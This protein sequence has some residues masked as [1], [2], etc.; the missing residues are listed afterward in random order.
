[1]HA[2]FL[3]FGDIADIVIP[4]GPTSR[5]RHRGFAFVEYED[6]KDCT[7]AVENMNLA[8]LYG[9]TLKVSMAKP[10]FLRDAFSKRP[11]WE[12]DDYIQK[13]G[14]E[15]LAGDDGNQ[16]EVTGSGESAVPAVEQGASAAAEAEAATKT[17]EERIKVF[18]EIS[19][20]GNAAGAGRI[21]MELRNDI[22]PR[23]A[24]NFRQLCT[25]SKGFGFRNSTF[26]RIIPGFM[27]QGGDFTKHNGTGGKSIYGA[28][29]DDENFKLK[30]TGPG[31]LSMANS[32]PNS[33]GSQFFI[34]TGK[35]DWLD[36][37]HVVFG[38]VLE[39]MPVV[40]MMEKCGSSSGTPSKRVVI[41][42]CGELSS[43]S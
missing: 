10:I 22:V 42:D 7:D 8:E 29:F 15:P 32:G 41:T 19:I 1:M 28:K 21:V 39:G 9:R 14:K 24:E 30:H 40:R 4:P 16:R 18:F 25:G 38:R 11:V 3:P 37:K 26:H 36:G 20:G 43:S 33:N 12:Q 6:A 17:T 5:Y 34:T 23:T 2:A 27:C 35:T 31:T 13:H